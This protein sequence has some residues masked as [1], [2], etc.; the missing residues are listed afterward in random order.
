MPTITIWN[1]ALA[2]GSCGVPAAKSF[3]TKAVNDF[4]ATK[5]GFN[6][7]IL[8]EPCDASNAFSTLLK[9]SE[10]AGTTP[11]IGQLYVGGQVIENA[12][13]LVALNNVLPS[14]FINSL[15]SWKYVT[16]GFGQTPNGNIYGVPFGNGYWYSVYYN[17]K[18]L[19]KAGI[20]NPAPATWNDLIAMAQKVKATGVT[21]IE[22]GEKEGYMGAWTQDSFISGLVG[23]DGVLSMYNGKESLNNPTLLAAYN[24]WHQLYASGVTNSDAP[25]LSYATAISNFA[26]GKAAMT[27]TAGFYNSTF[28]QGL[29]TNVGLFPVPTLPGSKFAQGLSGGPNNA[30]VVFKTSKHLPEVTKLLEY[31]TSLPVQ[32]NSVD[33]LGQLP[34][35]VSFKPDAA[36]AKSQPLLNDIAYWILT[37]HYTLGEAF[38]NIM[39]GTVMGYWYQT[40]SG[41]FGGSLSPA[42]AATSMQS[43]MQTYLATNSTG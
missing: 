41:V 10:L 11:D 8:Q 9:S 40:N 37:K 34:N 32:L 13:Y 12:K 15:T 31:L 38:D 6:V 21:P 29:G 25:S 26:A 39:P 28:T 43:Q 33:E 35:N 7:K 23:D 20:T 27:I 16:Q 24:A 17:K 2:S 42:S 3:L 4:L 1:D 14:S 30:Y 36:F 5:P 22:I 19:E 18:M